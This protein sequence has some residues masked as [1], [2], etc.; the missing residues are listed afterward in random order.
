MITIE[1]LQKYQCNYSQKCKTCDHEI[2]LWTQKDDNPEYHTD[3]YIH[4]V[5]GAFIHFSLPVN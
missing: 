1:E 3:I 2:T 5:C 4:C